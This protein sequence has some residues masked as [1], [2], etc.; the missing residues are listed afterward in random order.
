MKRKSDI[1]SAKP[2]SGMMMESWVSR[3]PIVE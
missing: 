1:G 2:A 3:S